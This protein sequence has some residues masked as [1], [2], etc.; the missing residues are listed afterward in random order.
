MINEEIYPT[1]ILRKMCHTRHNLCVLALG[2]MDNCL[3]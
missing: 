2:I 1:D 3:E